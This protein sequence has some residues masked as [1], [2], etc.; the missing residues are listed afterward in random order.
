MVSRLDEVLAA[1]PERGRAALRIFLCLSALLVDFEVVS[2]DNFAG[3]VLPNLSK[4]F[5]LATGLA[6][7]GTCLIASWVSTVVDREQPGLGFSGNLC[8]PHRRSMADFLTA[9]QKRDI[10]CNNAVRFLRLDN[11]PTQ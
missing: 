5:F 11:Q 2:G 4:H 1:D 10:F 3:V 7:L 8:E 9:E 6:A